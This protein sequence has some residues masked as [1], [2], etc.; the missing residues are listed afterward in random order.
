VWLRIDIGAR[1]QVLMDMRLS[2]AAEYKSLKE[3][4]DNL[5]KYGL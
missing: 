5:M 4:Y 3:H 1:A 2:Q